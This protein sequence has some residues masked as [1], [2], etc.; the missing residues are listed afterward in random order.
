MT[1]RNE[2]NVKLLINTLKRRLDSG[3]T[4]NPTRVLVAESGLTS[5]QVGALM[6]R[7]KK[8]TWHGMSIEFWTERVWL[9]KST[10]KAA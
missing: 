10:V 1:E 6:A 8:E 5:K 9:V 4:F 3:R 7:L 2:E